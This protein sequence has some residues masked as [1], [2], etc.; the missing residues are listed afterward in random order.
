MGHQAD[1]TVVL[2]WATLHGLV[3]LRI[4][5]PSFPW[6]PLRQLIDHA[7]DTTPLPP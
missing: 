7:V 2:L 4:S 5:R 6:P 3:T 1:L